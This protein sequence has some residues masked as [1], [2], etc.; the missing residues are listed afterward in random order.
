MWQKWVQLATLGTI[1]C[2]LRGAIGEVASI[3][4]GAGVSL[5]ALRECSGIASACG[6]PQSDAFLERQRGALTAQ[7]S[8][9]TS[10]MYRDLKKGEAVEVDTIL[11][12]LL[13]RGTKYGLATPILEAAFVSL[14]IY[15]RQRDRAKTESN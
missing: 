15:Q 4:G 7:G 11:G 13:E 9:L 3:S 6:H 5:A 12:D 2:L 1:T 14:S 8:Q 10:S